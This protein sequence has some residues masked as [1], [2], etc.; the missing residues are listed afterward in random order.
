MEQ[1]KQFYAQLPKKSF[2]TV[3]TVVLILCDVLILGYLYFKFSNEAFFQRTLG[4]SMELNGLSPAHMDPELVSSLQIMFHK[5][6]V[7]MLSLAAFYHVIN[8]VCWWNDKKFATTY[9]K[10]LTTIGGPLIILWGFG[11]LSAGSNV[12]LLY[13][14]MGAAVFSLKLGMNAHYKE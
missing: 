14:V 6:L 2:L 12:G 11:I 1:L 3:A 7:I 4:M 5:T 9:V 8:Y 10:F 13:L